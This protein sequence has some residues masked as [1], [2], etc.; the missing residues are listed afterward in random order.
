LDTAYL[1]VEFF[2]LSNGYLIVVTLD[3]FFIN[4]KVQLCLI[5]FHKY[6][7]ILTWG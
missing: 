4:L 3:N 1:L 6:L 7:Y 5:P 2:A